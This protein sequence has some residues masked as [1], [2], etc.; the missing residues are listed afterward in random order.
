MDEGR[1]VIDNSSHRIKI[2]LAGDEEPNNYLHPACL[3]TTESTWINP[4]NR[5]LQ[6]SEPEVLIPVWEKALV[7]GEQHGMRGKEV[8]MVNPIMTPHST[9]DKC[10]EIWFEL[11]DTP[12][13]L[14]KESTLTGCY[15]TGSTT[16]V[17]VE[18]GHSFCGAYS[19]FQGFD[20]W[21]S[22]R[23]V[24]FGGMELVNHYCLSREL[25]TSTPS[26]DEVAEENEPLYDQFLLPDGQPVNIPL[27]AAKQIPALLKTPNPT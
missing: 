21:D 18:V 15:W 14:I 13:M 4:L 25:L 5:N 23:L 16:M 22:R 9:D 17:A 19:F 24:R 7:M 27:S 2:G 11:F 12:G 8:M 3:D 6:S 1:I 20:L 10:A 26:L